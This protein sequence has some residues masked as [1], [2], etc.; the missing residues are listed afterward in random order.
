MPSVD[1]NG[2]PEYPPVTDLQPLMDVKTAA[3]A[4]RLA[5]MEKQADAELAKYPPAPEPKAA[6]AK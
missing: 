4:E 6:K 1:K 2:R 5:L 3:L